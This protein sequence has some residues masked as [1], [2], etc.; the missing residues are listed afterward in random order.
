MR[1]VP[2]GGLADMERHDH[3]VDVRLMRERVGDPPARPIVQ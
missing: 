1:L 3:H 2:P